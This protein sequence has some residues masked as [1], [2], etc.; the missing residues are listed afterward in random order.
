MTWWLGYAKAGKEFEVEQAAKEMGIFAWVPRKL[1]VKRV[2]KKRTPEIVERPFLP[3]IVFLEMDSH[4]WHQMQGAKHLKQT[5]YTL[6]R[7]DVLD[8]L[9]FRS[10][11]EAAQEAER[12]ALQNKGALCE[13]EPGQE[14]RV[15]NGPFVDFVARFKRLVENAYDLHPKYQVEVS[16]FGR[17]TML[18]I[19]P[20]DVTA[21]G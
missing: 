2:G 10:Q 12:R 6:N 21:E 7:K 11:I 13:Y 1:E 9:N 3:N 19:D 18:T 8:M 16:V 17:P 15:L 5:F 20:L 14:L 4:Q